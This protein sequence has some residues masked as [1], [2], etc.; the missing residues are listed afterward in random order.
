MY[1]IPV[2]SWS[3]VLLFIA[4]LS[5]FV[6]I[7][8]LEHKYRF[9]IFQIK[10]GF[11]ISYL[12][13]IY[14]SD[15]VSESIVISTGFSINFFSPAEKVLFIITLFII[16]LMY[17][18]AV[19]LVISFVSEIYFFSVILSSYRNT[20]IGIVKYIID[21]LYHSIFILF[22]LFYATIIFPKVLDF[23]S[24]EAYPIFNSV[25]VDWGFHNIPKHCLNKDQILKK[26]QEKS[27][28][29]IKIAILDVET[30][31]VSLYDNKVGDFKFELDKCQRIAYPK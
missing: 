12:T 15:I 20:Q 25:L 9:N 13:S 19:G 31:L 27:D 1:D 26:Y 23:T 24:K 10:L 5:F 14:I 30:I 2:K 11:I 7:F 21:L 8:C 22:P 16:F 6:L 29:D 17:F 18:P 4:I 3:V 28:R